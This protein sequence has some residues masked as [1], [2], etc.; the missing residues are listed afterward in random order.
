MT[1]AELRKLVDKGRKLKEQADSIDTELKKV[2]EVFRKEAKSRKIDHFLGDLN[3][4]KVSP[5]T[6]TNCDPE[7]FHETMMELD[8]LDEYY[9]C[10]KVKITEAKAA[11]GETVFNS[12]SSSESIPYQKVSFLAKAP[13]KYLE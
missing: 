3:F 5:Q 13:K 10:I 1:N 9:D 4:C 2:K 12:I 8:R 11:L 7:Q 6:V